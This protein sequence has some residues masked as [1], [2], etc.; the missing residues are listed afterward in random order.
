MAKRGP[1]ASFV[2][3]NS[4]ES[5]I[6]C[7]NWDSV[8]SMLCLEIVKIMRVLALMAEE[9]STAMISKLLIPLLEQA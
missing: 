1:L 2:W 3:Q 7:Q 6:V 4:S 5:L 9:R 8:V